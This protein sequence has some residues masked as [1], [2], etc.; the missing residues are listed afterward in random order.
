[1]CYKTLVFSNPRRGMSDPEGALRYE[2]HQRVITN[3]LIV[4]N[5]LEKHPRHVSYGFH[6]DDW[7]R[8][9]YAGEQQPEARPA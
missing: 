5:V 7:V 4:T 9:I 3:A 1:M 2:R 6:I 8:T